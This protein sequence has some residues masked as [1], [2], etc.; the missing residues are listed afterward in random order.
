MLNISVLSKL[1]IKIWNVVVVSRPYE[2]F[3]VSIEHF[4]GTF[5]QYLFKNRHKQSTLRSSI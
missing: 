1:I 2:M 5:K 4:L 3:K